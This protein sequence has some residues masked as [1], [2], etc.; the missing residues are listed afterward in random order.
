VLAHPKSSPCAHIQDALGILKLRLANITLQGEGKDVMNNVKT[1]LFSLIIRQQVL[2]SPIR[3]I[4]TA[5]LILVVE[6]G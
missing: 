5:I 6:D 4:A 3:M 1:L 2:A